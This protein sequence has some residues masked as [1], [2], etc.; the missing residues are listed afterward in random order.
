MG[1][2]QHGRA[3][4]CPWKCLAQCSPCACWHIAAPTR[5]HQGP[6]AQQHKKGLMAQGHSRAS[7]SV[8]NVTDVSL[9]SLETECHLK[10]NQQG[11]PGHAFSVSTARPP[12]SPLTLLQ[13]QSLVRRSWKICVLQTRSKVSLG[14]RGLLRCSAPREGG[15]GHGGLQPGRAGTSQIFGSKF[16]HFL[17]AWGRKSL[18]LAEQ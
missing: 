5:C 4:L 8:T 1:T 7:P 9:F 18:F 6:D 17:E 10:I 11:C 15:P 3:L 16:Q 2:L 12:T 13:T 14:V